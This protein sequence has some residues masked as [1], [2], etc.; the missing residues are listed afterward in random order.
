MQK[1]FYQLSALLSLLLSINCFSQPVLKVADIF[2]DNMVLQADSELNVW[3]KGIPA[4]EV[5][6]KF[7]SQ[8]KTSLLNSNG[9]WKLVLE[10]E[11]YGGPD[12]LVIISG[13]EKIVFENVMVGEVWIC[14]GQSNM[15][16]PLISNWAHVVNAEDEAHFSRLIL[17]SLKAGWSAA[18]SLSETFRQQHI[19]LEEKF[20]KSWEFRLV[21]F[22][23]P[24]A[25]PLRKRGQVKIHC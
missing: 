10:E 23:H 12:S 20:I 18:R 19:F 16:M 21:L 14:S 9:E 13:S 1:S 24:G 22:I 2:G 6:V 5:E 11:S 15:E 4:N 8:A 7:R 17:L 25:V 3:G